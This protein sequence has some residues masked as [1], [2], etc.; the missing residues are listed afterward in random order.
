M[1]ICNHVW[2]DTVMPT[3]KTNDSELLASIKN[4][5]GKGWWLKGR[6]FNIAHKL[7]SMGKIKYCKNC[8][9]NRAVLLK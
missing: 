8:T 2:R 6:E 9:G 4:T 1:S 3:P 7:V 5:N